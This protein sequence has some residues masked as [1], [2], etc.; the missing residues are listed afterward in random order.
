MFSFALYAMRSL[1]ALFSTVLLSSES[2]TLSSA[3]SILY[4][5]AS[6][7]ASSR[8]SVNSSTRLFSAK[9]T[10]FNSPMSKSR[11]FKRAFICKYSCSVAAAR[12]ASAVA[13][14]SAAL[15]RRSHALNA[16]LNRRTCCVNSATASDSRVAAVA[17]SLAHVARVAASRANVSTSSS[18]TFKFNVGAVHACGS[19][20]GAGAGSPSRAANSPRQPR[21]TSPPTSPSSSSRARSSRASSSRNALRVVAFRACARARSR[22]A[23]RTRSSARSNSASRTAVSASSRARTAASSAND[24]HASSSTSS[25][26]LAPGAARSTESDGQRGAAGVVMWR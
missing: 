17:A 18:S 16:E 2:F 11:A 21:A 3:I 19:V 4:F 20:L 8:A 25:P 5:S 15:S 26:S 1:T 13:A 12:S 23:S 9:T 24:T 10:W 7:L 14:A 22:F 6:R